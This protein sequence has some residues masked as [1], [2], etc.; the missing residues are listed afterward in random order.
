MSGYPESPANGSPESRD[1]QQT[2]REEWANAISHGIGLMVAVAA[3][4]VLIVHSAGQGSAASIV[5]ASIFGASLLMLY[6]ASTVYHA[7]PVSRAKRVFKVL[8]HCA[9]YLLI[10]GTYTPFALGVLRGSWGWSLF[11]IIWGL[12]ALGIL[13]KTIFVPRGGTV[14]TC[15]YI[16]MGWLIVVALK[17]IFESMPAAGIG[18]LLA[19]G[20]AYTAGVA[21]YA[22]GH[23]I[24]YGHFA[25]HLFVLAGSV[26]HFIAVY[27]YST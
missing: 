7:L 2:A 16:A 12:A 19:G 10:A 20:V 4:P 3:V 11:G 26:S 27:K 15:L 24:R 9:I 22:L 23:R 17:K 25:W 6:L 1:R 5:A 21:F 8:D 13:T 14:S 18:W